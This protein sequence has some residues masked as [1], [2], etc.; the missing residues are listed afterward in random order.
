[1]STLT[2]TIEVA[3]TPEAVWA[4]VSDLPGMGRLSPEATGGTWVKGAT[5]PAVGARFKGWNASGGRS[6]TTL[7]KVTDAV[8][9]EVFAFSVTSAGLPVATWRYALTPTAAGCSVTETWVDRRGALISR[10][11]ALVT[12]VRDRETTNREGMRVTLQRVKAAAEVT[13]EA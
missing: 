11:G 3:A 1:M 9:G 6:W 5:G 12:G 4:L 2:E 13:R 8:P 10:L 7:A